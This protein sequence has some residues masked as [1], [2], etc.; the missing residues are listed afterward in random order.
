M[1]SAAVVVAGDEAR[2]EVAES[3][4]VVTFRLFAVCCFC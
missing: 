2:D 1:A 4:S 3:E